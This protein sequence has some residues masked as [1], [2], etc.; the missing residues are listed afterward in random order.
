MAE[1]QKFFKTGWESWE[2]DSHSGHPSSDE[3]SM[4]AMPWY[5]DINNEQY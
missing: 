2:D 5:S 1:W 4:E 3:K